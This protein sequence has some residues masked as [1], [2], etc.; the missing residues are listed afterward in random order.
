MVSW[1][2]IWVPRTTYVVKTKTVSRA[3][4]TSYERTYWNGPLI[5]YSHSLCVIEKS[6]DIIPFPNL[7][8]FLTEHLP[9]LIHNAMARDLSD[10]WGSQTGEIETW[11]TCSQNGLFVINSEP[12][13][14]EDPHV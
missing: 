6:I 13:K 9:L 10:I 8:N 11:Y 7:Q 5:F 2:G 14:E 3:V 12:D 4:S 1:R